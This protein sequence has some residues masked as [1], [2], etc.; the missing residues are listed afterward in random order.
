MSDK[1]RRTRS[2]QR[3]ARIRAKITGESHTAAS[4]ALEKYEAL[5]QLGWALNNARLIPLDEFG[6]RNQHLRLA[7]EADGRH[8]TVTSAAMILRGTGCPQCSTPKVRLDPDQAAAIMREARLVPLEPYPGKT[9]VPW[10]CRCGVCDRTVAPR[11]ANIRAGQ[12]G[13]VYCRDFRRELD[14]TGP[15]PL[16]V[17]A[18]PEAGRV[19][20]G[21]KLDLTPGWVGLATID[22][23][24]GLEQRILRALLDYLHRQGI[25]PIQP[26]PPGSS[27]SWAT[28]FSEDDIPADDFAELVKRIATELENIGYEPGE[29][30]ED[31][32]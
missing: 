1:S 2:F 25:Q 10:K 15:T 7:C 11:L 6:G 16:D 29:P 5:G 18:H 22:C 9:T 3:R 13:C 26:E 17:I 24:G 20:I 30:G 19:M 28:T 32:A 23:A 8:L 21:I 14:L 4:K 31:A 12:G 27:P